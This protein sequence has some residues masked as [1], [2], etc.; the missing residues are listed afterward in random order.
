MKRSYFG[1]FFS[2][3]IVILT[4][5]YAVDRYEVMVSYGNSVYESTEKDNV[6]AFGN[7]LTYEITGFDIAVGLKTNEWSP[8]HINTTGYVEI[9]LHILHWDMARRENEIRDYKP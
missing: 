5:S 6:I 4:L 1:A 7:E 3:A 8:I 9:N 2:I